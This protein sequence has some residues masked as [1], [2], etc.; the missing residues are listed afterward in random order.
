MYTNL[1]Y[2][3]TGRQKHLRGTDCFRSVETQAGSIG[4]TI[5]APLRN[6]DQVNNILTF[7]H[8]GEDDAAEDELVYLACGCSVTGGGR[9][10]DVSRM[11]V[12]RFGLE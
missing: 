2:V 5:V 3:V 1:K 11:Q 6:D 9:P 4:S 8:D 10:I 7:I 12:Q